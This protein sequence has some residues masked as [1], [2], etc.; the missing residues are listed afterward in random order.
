MPN[1]PPKTKA[2]L[3]INRAD[4]SLRRKQIKEAANDLN[5]AEQL[6]LNEFEQQGQFFELF[7]GVKVR[8]AEI[9]S[10]NR[11]YSAAIDKFE[12]GHDYLLSYFST[13]YR[14]EFGKHHIAVG[15]M[16]QRQDSLRQAL[17]TYQKA[18]TSVLPAYQ[19]TDPWT[20]P[21]AEDI[22]PEN[23]IQ[24][25]LEHMADVFQK[26]HARDPQQRYLTTALA[27][28]D[29]IH[30]VERAL[31]RSYRYESAKLGS[32]EETRTRTG[33]AIALAQQL[34]KITQDEDYLYRA[35]VF[36]ERSR[37]SL[38]R[39][40][41]RASRAT[42]L[43]GISAA[44]Q[45]QE[46][47]L[48]YAISEAEEALFDAQSQSGSDSLVRAAKQQLFNAREALQQWVTQLEN[49]NPRYYQLK[50]AET[51][52][53]VAEMRQLL[54]PNQRLIEY[55]TD[56]NQLYVF[57]LGQQELLTLHVLDQPDSLDQRILNWRRSIEEFQNAGVDRTALMN[58]YRQGAYGLYQ[59]L[60]A[61]LL[62]S[63]YDYTD[64]LVVTSGLLDLVPFEALL[65][66][67]PNV[68]TSL[69]GYPYLLQDYVISYSY[70]AT[71]Q[72]EL[73]QLPMQGE[74]RLGIAPA[75]D[76]RAGWP[77]LSCSS[78]LL[79]RVLTG[80]TD[81]VQL[82]K[83]ATAAAFRTA[84]GQYQ[85]LHLA[86]H[87]QANAEQGDF[88]F[89][90][91]S[92]GQGGYDSLFAKDLYLESIPSEL[93][94]LSACETALGTLYNSEGVISLARGFHFAGARSVLTTL[95]RI[96]ENANCNLLEDFYAEL[97][98][99]ATKSAA[100]AQAKRQYLTQADERAA[101]PVYWAGFQLLGNP[102]AVVM[103]NAFWLWGVG[104]SGLLLGLFF[105]F[106]RQN[107]VA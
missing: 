50:Y 91:F 1:L 103:R 19:P 80:S 35:F 13:P 68:N 69:T 94:M 105:W 23:T 26:L 39:E 97:D 71:L 48:Q 33:K 87:A 75:F 24:E 66:A 54:G 20:L 86:T 6:L 58:A 88:S 32:L 106:K 4:I 31:R 15:D 44:D 37:S 14:R 22:Y 10:L 53:S 7:A 45:A 49:N 92:D 83:N 47:D 104:V 11:D 84:A 93:V 43:A 78:G 79:E 16:Y 63:E 40:A 21:Q 99:G 8:Q 42:Q 61:P 29:L 46:E 67:D 34:Y 36:A 90:V 27:C 65:S 56:K 30:E 76:G 51:V 95:W 57:T 89:V 81:N 59:D 18:L 41:Y 28:H 107:G 25:A 52:P 55:F 72:W 12:E 70:S 74:G 98:N 5:L 85:L 62:T 60:V 73:H 77:R 9:H 64:W 17:N 82:A 38:L 102:R 2:L 96:N 101:H 3:A 100:L